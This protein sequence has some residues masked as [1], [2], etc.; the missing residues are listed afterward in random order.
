M[1][2]NNGCVEDVRG[3]CYISDRKDVYMMIS[4]SI[5]KE[6]KFTMLLVT[7]PQEMNQVSG[8]I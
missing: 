8:E 1:T 4:T 7:F 3:N 6:N 2:V 5:V